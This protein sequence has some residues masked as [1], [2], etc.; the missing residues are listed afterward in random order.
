MISNSSR[1]ATERVISGVYEGPSEGLRGIA[2][3]SVAVR[4]EIEAENSEPTERKR[5]IDE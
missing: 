4:S 2:V 5:E 3:D 1:P